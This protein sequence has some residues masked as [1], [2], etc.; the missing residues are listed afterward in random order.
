MRQSDCLSNNIAAALGHG[1]QRPFTFK[2]LGLV[3]DL[4]CRRAVAKILGVK[5][6]GL[7]AW[8]F[9]R[10]YHLMALPGNAGAPP[11]RVDS[12]AL[13]STRLSRM[14]PG[15]DAAALPHR[16]D[17][18]GPCSLGIGRG[19][20]RDLEP[21]M[22]GV[23][24]QLSDHRRIDQVASRAV[25]GQLIPPRNDIR[26][27]RMT[28]YDLGVYPPA[29]ERHRLRVAARVRPVLRAATTVPL[30]VTSTSPA[31]A[32]PHG[33]SSQPGSLGP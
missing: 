2:T 33:T 3:V 17:C 8:F 19:F 15:E 1:K 18:D 31:A 32:T 11:A 23:R 30:R 20:R 9:A 5:L 27:V 7:P 13:L 12:R 6:R 29:H 24:P 22:E 21:V 28:S 26:R 16:L 4:G 14:D 10:T 25:E